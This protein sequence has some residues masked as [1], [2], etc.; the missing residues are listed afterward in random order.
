MFEGTPERNAGSERGVG[1]GAGWRGASGGRDWNRA[2]VLQ[3]PR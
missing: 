1:T 2:N 3:A